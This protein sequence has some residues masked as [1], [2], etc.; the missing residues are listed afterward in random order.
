MGIHLEGGDDNQPRIDT[1]E[2]FEEINEL[3]E[4]DALSTD[5]IRDSRKVNSIATIEAL[6]LK[7]ISLFR[8]PIPLCRLVAMPIVRPI[9]PS[10]LASLEDT[11]VHGYWEE[12]AVFYLSTTNEDG[13]VDKVSDNDLQSSGPLWCAINNFFEDSCF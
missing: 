8:M 6:C 5:Q 2:D 3:D 7:P 9:L 11:F 13:L 1:E 12:A 4:E 10:D